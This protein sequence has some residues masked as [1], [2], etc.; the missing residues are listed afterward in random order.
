MDIL[1]LLIDVIGFCQREGILS[2]DERLYSELADISMT[3]LT[4]DEIE[5][6]I[7]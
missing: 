7:G 1:D 6:I 2:S 5:E 4:A 3:E